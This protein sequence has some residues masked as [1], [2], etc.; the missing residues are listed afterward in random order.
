MFCEKNIEK[1]FNNPK[2]KK[3]IKNLTKK[4]FTK[5]DAKRII[6]RIK[7]RGNPVIICPYYYILNTLVGKKTS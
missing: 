4:P 1:F 6:Q 3:L 2:T 7:S 5:K